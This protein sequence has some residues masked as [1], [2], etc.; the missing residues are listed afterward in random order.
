MPSSSNRVT[1][2]IFDVDDTLYDVGTGFTAQRNGEIVQQFMVDHFKFPSLEAAKEVRDSYF[3]KY[4]ATAKA[5]AVAQK[6]GKFPEGAPEFKTEALAEYWAENL[7]YDI[8]G[9]P[10]ID[11]IET[12]SKC[13]CTLVAFSNGPR[14]YVKR[15]LQKLGLFELFGDEKLYAVDDVLPYC[16]PEKEA[17]EKIFQKIGNP[18]PDSCVMVEDSM[19]NIRRAKDV[20]M[21]TVLITGKSET[22]RILP[23]D[24]PETSDP[25]V[26]VSMQTIEEFFEVLPGLLDNEAP[27][28]EPKIPSSSNN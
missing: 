28:F 15:V 10:K 19:K 6:D 17:F 2:L 14:K 12:L 27:V 24:K 20:G 4:H 16:K 25:A 23:E 18:S 9:P 21:K 11:L 1:T 22:G 13:P 3:A 7:D 5:L 8:L 26:D